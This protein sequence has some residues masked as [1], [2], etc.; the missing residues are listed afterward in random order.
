MGLP[1]KMPLIS[2]T[3]Y[4]KPTWGEYSGMHV[5][6]RAQ[7]AHWKSQG[8]DVAKMFLELK[9]V[10]PVPRAETWKTTAAISY[11]S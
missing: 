4:T 6:P 3:W 5:A 7:M 9:P 2:G 11:Y 8:G 1:E 10:D